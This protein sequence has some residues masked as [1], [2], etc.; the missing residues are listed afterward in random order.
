MNNSPFFSIILP[1]Y[2]MAKWVGE[3]L[4]SVLCQ[5]FDDYEIICVN[6]GSRDN[7][8]EILKSYAEKHSCIRIIDRENGGVSSA[9]NCGVC[10]AKGM[11]IFQLD[12]DDLMCEGILAK[13]HKAIIDADYPDMLQASHIELNNGVN[14]YVD[15]PYPGDKYFSREISRDE[16]AIRLWLDRHIM[17]FTGTRFLKREFLKFKNL[18]FFL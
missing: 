15:R 17:P 5:D 14:K 2:N 3:S 16:R 11:Y 6:D 18:K 12:S 13:A 10:L 4:D 9:R 1:V 7:S 8:L